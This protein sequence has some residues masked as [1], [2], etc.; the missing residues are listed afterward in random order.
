MKFTVK[1]SLIGMA[2]MSLLA[3]VASHADMTKG[4]WIGDGFNRIAKDGRGSTCVSSGGADHAFDAPQCAEA[5]KEAADAAAAETA[6][7]KAAKAEAAAAAAAAREDALFATEPG[8]AL[9]PGDPGPYVSSGNG[10]MVRD[11]YGSNCVKDGGWDISLA[12]EECDPELFNRYRARQQPQSELAPR[13]MS[14]PPEAARAEPAAQSAAAISSIPESDLRAAPSIYRQEADRAVVFAP[15]VA[16][17]GADDLYDTTADAKPEVL[18]EDT[19][20]TP[21]Q[22]LSDADR[23]LPG[24]SGSTAIIAAVPMRSDDEA[25][26]TDD[27]PLADSSDAEEVTP[28]MMMSDADRQLDNGDDG[29]MAFVPVPIADEVDDKAKPEDP[30]DAEETT[31]DMIM[32]DADRQLDNGDDGFM[33]FVPVPIADEVDDKAKPED[34][35]DAEETTPDMIMSDADR[36]LDNGDDGFMA[37]VPVPIADEVD[38]KAKPE[39][40]VD[41]EETT[42]DMIMSDAD[43]QLDNGDDGFMAFAPIPVEDEENDQPKRDDDAEAEETTPDMML[44]EADRTL[45]EDEQP[46]PGVA[47]LTDTSPGVA[48]PPEKPVV[49]QP[50]VDNNLPE[51]PITNNAATEAPAAAAAPVAQPEKAPVEKPKSLPVTINVKEDGLFDFD[52]ADLRSEVVIKL[53]GVADMLDEAKYDAINIIGYADPIGTA[54]YNQLLSMRRAEAAKK[55]LVRKGIDPSRINTSGKGENDLIVTREDCAGQRKEALIECLQPNRRVVVEAAGTMP[56]K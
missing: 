12:T 22:M 30:I 53:D 21:D 27:T 20:V 34:P 41:A 49:T 15:F 10:N 31:P 5:A 36:Q 8:S 44:S 25:D 35:I 45:P 51:F 19:E 46:A 3:P 32:S 17:S 42:P 39:D 16:P 4:Q 9:K 2:A 54:D 48:P 26:E 29:F 14:A 23:T 24:E 38:D 52:R 43:R 1:R 37:F 11:G 18:P 6:A 50:I 40:P 28:E 56:A 47:V 7:R 55:Y 33:A 13:Q